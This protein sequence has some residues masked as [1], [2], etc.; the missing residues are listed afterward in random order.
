MLTSNILTLVL[1]LVCVSQANAVCRPQNELGYHIYF[2]GSNGS[3]F[4][5]FAELN[6]VRKVQEILK[7]RHS[8]V[9]LGAKWIFMIYGYRENLNSESVQ[10]ILK[11]YKERG[12]FIVF[13]LEWSIF[14]HGAN[15]LNAINNAREIAP[16]IG[17]TLNNE[18]QNQNVINL[19]LFEFVGIHIGAHFAAF[20]SREIYD[21]SGHLLKIPRITGI[22]PAG[23]IY[24]DSDSLRVLEDH[25]NS[26]D[27]ENGALQN[28]KAK[29]RL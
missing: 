8:Y 17:A 23:R 29:S 10:T 1:V 2:F 7:N 11:A 5:E 20:I 22:D 27:G 24:F 12:H 19:R 13:V 21:K 18:L 9:N 15:Q 26:D 28:R 6:N 16:Q 3:E 14:N 25:L 4:C